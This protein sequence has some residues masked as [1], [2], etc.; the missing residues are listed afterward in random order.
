MSTA[1]LGLI[2]GVAFVLLGR[3]IYAR[4]E[5]FY[6]NSLQANSEG[7]LPRLVAKVF[8]VLLIFLGSY[9]AV[10][11]PAETFIHGAVAITSLGLVAG[12]LAS[13]F[14]RPRAGGAVG[15][16]P[17]ASPAARTK[18]GPILTRKGKVFLATMIGGCVVMGAE[19][20]LLPVIGRA[21]LVP[22]VGMTTILIWATAMLLE[23]LFVK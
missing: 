16:G 20:F 2:A 1:M 5:T 11:A 7:S 9:A 4:P 19:T 10:V 18:Q 12:T 14:L 22:D 17:V 23:M 3:W 8:A 15:T 21:G 13:L 6:A